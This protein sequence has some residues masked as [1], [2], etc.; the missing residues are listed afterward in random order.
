MPIL[1]IRALPQKNPS[2]IKLALKKTCLAIAKFYNCDAKHVWATWEEIRPGWYIEGDKDFNV[3]PKDTHPPIAQLTCFEGLQSQQVEDLLKLT[4][5]T[6]SNHLDI[7]DNIFI[8]YH[9]AKSGK[10]IA[11]N[12]LVKK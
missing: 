11:N 9:E 3:Q 8:T 1:H 5:Q 7:G 10:V 6:L 12:Q 2:K 4:S